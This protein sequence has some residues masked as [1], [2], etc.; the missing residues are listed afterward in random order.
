M[1]K[2][3]R[4]KDRRPKRNSKGPGSTVFR[5]SQGQCPT[6]SLFESVVSPLHK[7]KEDRGGGS[8]EDSEVKSKEDRDKE[9]ESKKDN[10]KEKEERK[11]EEE[12]KRRKKKKGY[13]LQHAY[14]YS[15]TY[16]YMLRL[17]YTRQVEV[18][19]VDGMRWQ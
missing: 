3:E 9:K 2:K 18:D 13:R 1:M 8:K 6:S 19:E 15:Y 17:H 5:Q 12:E 4:K 10:G 7:F 14:S 16:G 11:E